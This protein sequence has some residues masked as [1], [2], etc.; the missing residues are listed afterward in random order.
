M[1]NPRK[2]A[3]AWKGL[4]IGSAAL[5]GA[6][7]GQQAPVVYSP[8]P[9]E[10]A[11]YYDRSGDTLRVARLLDVN[12]QIE[13]HQATLVE[14]HTMVQKAAPVQRVPADSL[15]SVQSKLRARY[16]WQPYVSSSPQ[17][18]F[19]QVDPEGE[20]REETF[21]NIIAIMNQRNN[22]EE[23]IS[24]ELAR[25][26]LGSWAASD[27]GPGGMNILYDVKSA[28]AALPAVVRT[29]EAHQAQGRARIARRL[30][31]SDDDW[32]YEVVYPVGFTG[33]FNSM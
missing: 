22:L 20:H 23:A 30:M 16:H 15:A 5:L 29:L 31:T 17:E 26:Q 21:L 33:V 14:N 32:R 10:I 8:V 11:V 12:E 27:L 18:L 25:Q 28:T 4:L 9:R 3:N 13:L 6:G 19:V 2:G 24:D 7:C 1:R